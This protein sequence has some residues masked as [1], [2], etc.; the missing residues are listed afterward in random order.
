MR[1]TVALDDDLVRIAQ[2][3]RVLRRIQHCFVKV[4]KPS[5]RAK[6]HA[7]WLPWV[8]PYRG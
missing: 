7:D 6:L 5:L 2:E 8:V 3:Y 1:I 4:S